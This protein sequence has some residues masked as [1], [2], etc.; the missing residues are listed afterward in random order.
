MLLLSMLPA[1]ASM[2]H[3][4]PTVSSTRLRGTTAAIASFLRAAPAAAR[5]AAAAAGRR[6]LLLHCRCGCSR[7][8]QVSIPRV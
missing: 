2:L 6:R 7:Q 4:G 5:C 1:A 8:L 3:R